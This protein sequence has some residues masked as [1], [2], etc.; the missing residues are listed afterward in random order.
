MLDVF[1]VSLASFRFILARPVILCLLSAATCTKHKQARATRRRIASTRRGKRTAAARLGAW[2]AEDAGRRTE[3]GAG[4]CVALLS[5]VARRLLPAL[6]SATVISSLLYSL[7]PRISSLLLALSAPCCWYVRR[8]RSLSLCGRCFKD[9]HGFLRLRQGRRRHWRFDMRARRVARR[10]APF[11]LFDRA[12]YAFAT[13]QF[14]LP[15]RSAAALT[16]ASLGPSQPAWP[17]IRTLRRCSL[18]CL[19]ALTVPR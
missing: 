19:L 8:R 14:F 1:C 11:T 10:C 9:C 2:A 12:L 17:P 6:V 3:D 16:P 5:P 7:S 13:T 15:A 18:L 4:G